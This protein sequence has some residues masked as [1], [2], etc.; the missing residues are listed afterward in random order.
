MGGQKE[1]SKSSK[2]GSGKVNYKQG[3]FD[4]LMKIGGSNVGNNGSSDPK[5]IWDRM[6]DDQKE[7]RV[8]QL[9]E[10]ARRYNN[11]LRL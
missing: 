11:K 6:T 10:K 5:D 1:R 8:T 2:G 7:E 4:K 9:W 3:F